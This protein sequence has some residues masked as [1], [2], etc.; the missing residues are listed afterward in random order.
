MSKKLNSGGREGVS[1]VAD[2]GFKICQKMPKNDLWGAIWVP[3]MSK[4]GS[5]CDGTNVDDEETPL[6]ALHCILHPFRGPNDLFLGPKYHKISLD[7][8]PFFCI[9]FKFHLPTL[10]LNAM[11]CVGHPC[12]DK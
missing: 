10:H 6:I 2:L 11:G 5:I 3:K 4:E 7:K 12:G 1:Q 8:H 9:I